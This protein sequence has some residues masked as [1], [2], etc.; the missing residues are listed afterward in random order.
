MATSSKRLTDTE[1]Q[2]A[3]VPAGNK[4]PVYLRDPGSPGLYVRIT[5]NGTKTFLYRAGGENGKDVQRWLSLGN[6][7]PNHGS[8]AASCGDGRAGHP[9]SRSPVRSVPKER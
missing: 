9:V 5:P 4:N 1:I 6:S 8:R 7:D 2:T 3:K